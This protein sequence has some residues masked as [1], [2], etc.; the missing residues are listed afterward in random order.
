M[1]TDKVKDDDLKKE[2]NKDIKEQTEEEKEFI[3][4]HRQFDR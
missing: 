2:K 1:K 4:I 3:K